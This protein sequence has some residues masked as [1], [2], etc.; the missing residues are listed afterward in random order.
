MT[1]IRRDLKQTIDKNSN[2]L[3]KKKRRVD[4]VLEL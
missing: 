2:K 1:C 4:F 3:I